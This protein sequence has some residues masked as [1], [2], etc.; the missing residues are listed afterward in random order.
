MLRLDAMYKFDLRYKKII[1][2]VQTSKHG[3]IG[4]WLFSIEVRRL[5]LI[6]ITLYD[7]FGIKVGD[8]SNNL[9]LCSNGKTV[10]A[11]TSVSSVNFEFSVQEAAIFLQGSVTVLFFYIIIEPFATEFELVWGNINAAVRLGTWAKHFR[12]C[13]LFYETRSSDDFFC[14]WHTTFGWKSFRL[15]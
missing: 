7:F 13:E 5:S 14:V 4:K 3:T 6:S 12:I 10:C 15:S 8:S 1:K 9:F 2:I 11:E